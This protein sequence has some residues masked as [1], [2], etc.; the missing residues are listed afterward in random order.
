MS[1][2]LPLEGWQRLSGDNIVG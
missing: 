1:F 2:Q